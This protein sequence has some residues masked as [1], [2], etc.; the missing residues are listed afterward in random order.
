MSAIR[1]IRSEVFGVTQAEF[2][3]LS[4]VTQATV[5]RWESGGSP[6]LE[7]LRAIRD[8]ALKR[9]I[10]WQDEWFFTSQDADSVTSGPDAA[11]LKASGP[12]LSHEAAA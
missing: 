5:S 4:G 12:V 11:D 2:A 6:N 10:E 1:F 7:E 9:G 8:A 3:V